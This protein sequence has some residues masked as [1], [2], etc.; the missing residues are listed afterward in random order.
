MTD[1]M[2]TG[3]VKK[4]GEVAG[5][6]ASLHDRIN[7]L[8]KDL[9]HIDG[10]LRIVAPDMPVESIRPKMFRPPSDWSKRGQMSRIV[11]NILRQAKEPLT[12][13]E[14]AAQLILERGMAMDDK[15][16]RLMTKRCG[17]ALRIQRDKGLAVSTEGNGFHLLWVIVR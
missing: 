17:V 9:D 7:Q 6:I 11:L 5:E 13:R 16:L 2:V 14:I 3:L 10:T 8:V 1:Y 4:R 12:S 15:L